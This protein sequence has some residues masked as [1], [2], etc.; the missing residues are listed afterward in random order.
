MKWHEYY[1]ERIY[2]YSKDVMDD[3]LLLMARGGGFPAKFVV[4]GVFDEQGVLNE[5]IFWEGT[6]FFLVI[7]SIVVDEKK[8]ELHITVQTRGDLPA[9][10]R[11][12]TYELTFTW[13]GFSKELPEEMFEDEEVPNILEHL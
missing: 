13:H 3:V 11:H 7:R 6:F 5:D 1:G 9:G 2:L 4:P 10:V 8:E 12:G